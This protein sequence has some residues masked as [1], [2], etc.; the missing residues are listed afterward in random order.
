M[1]DALLLFTPTLALVATDMGVQVIEVVLAEV[2]A[3][4]STE[5][6]ATLVVVVTTMPV[7]VV[8]T[9]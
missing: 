7:F 6:G 3:V 9:Q 5:V 4:I 2:G 8:S 1:T